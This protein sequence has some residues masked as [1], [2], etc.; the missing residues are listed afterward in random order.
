MSEP[1]RLRRSTRAW[2]S[3]RFSSHWRLAVAGLIGIVAYQAGGMA[4]VPGKLQILTAWDAAAATYVGLLWLLFLR[5]D[6]QAI[7]IRASQQDETAGVILLIAATAIIASLGGIV[8]VLADL[9]SHRG[10]T[11][12]TASMVALTL[13]LGWALQQSLFV[14]H[15]AHRHFAEEAKRPGSGF[16]FAGDPPRSYLDFVYLSFTIGATFQVSDNTVGC[17]RLRN[18]VTAHGALAYVYNTAILAIGINLLA[19]VVTQ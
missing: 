2:I 17:S 15:Y 18:L 1:D 3:P 10:D 4:N 11:Q 6:E 9:K 14:P 16:G 8:A 19:S 7:R 13:A 5:N 12:V